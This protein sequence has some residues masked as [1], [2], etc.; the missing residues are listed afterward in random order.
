MA[1]KKFPKLTK[2]GSVMALVLLAVILLLLSGM[3]VLTIGQTVRMFSIRT[4]ADVS[5]RSAAD[6]GITKAVYAMNKKLFN[7][8]WNP[9]QNFLWEFHK[10][11]SNSSGAEYSYFVLPSELYG[12]VMPSGD[13]DLIDFVNSAVGDVGDYVVWSL[14]RY[15]TAQK[16]IRAIVRLK[17]CGDTGVLVRDKLTLKADTLVAGADSRNG[18][19]IDPEVLVEI[20]TISIGDQDVV[21]NNNVTVAGNVAVGVGGNVA[22]VIKDL[23][24]TTGLRYAMPEEPEFPYIY[25][26]TASAAFIYH[27]T[28]LGIDKK[29]PPSPD[30]N[31][32]VLTE[33]DNGIYKCI[34]LE[35]NNLTQKIVIA[36]GNNVV[37]HL[38]NTGTGTSQAGI[39]LGV[40]CEIVIEDGATLNLYVDGNIRSGVDSGFNNLG[41]PPDFKIWGNWRPPL[42]GQNWQLNA[43]SEYFGQVYA[44]GADIVVQAKGDLFGAF[45]GNTF[46]MRN[47]GNLIYDGALRQVDSGDEGV[48]FVLKRWYE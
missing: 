16:P 10:T 36:S 24:A 2:R 40:G 35:S 39:M 43:K 33:A 37:L 31:V 5:A 28:V 7:G 4:A 8:T 13:D 3:G 1:R 32:L 27:N 21:L 42:T 14:G 25:P 30:P 20:G 45:T 41:T 11:L 44:P 19:E 18:P 15:T 29:N 17:G 26:P 48:R 22:T 34:D 38:T 6:A 12:N 46:D 9:N 23:G 47:G